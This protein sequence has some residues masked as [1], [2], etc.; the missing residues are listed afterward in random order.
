M[1]RAPRAHQQHS[2]PDDIVKYEDAI[3]EVKREKTAL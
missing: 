3:E 2:R 1:K